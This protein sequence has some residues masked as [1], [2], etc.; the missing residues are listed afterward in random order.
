MSYCTLFGAVYSNILKIIQYFMR[1]RS[2]LWALILV[3]ATLPTA[4]CL[5]RTRPVEETYSKA[6]LKE[7]SQEALIES[8]KQQSEKIQSLQATV[9]IDTSAEASRRATLP[10]T[11]KFADM[12]WRGS[13]RCCT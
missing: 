9:D 6:P 13:P 11:R 2:P 4:G 7:S 12:S 5:F 1:S 3:V 10:I 8:L